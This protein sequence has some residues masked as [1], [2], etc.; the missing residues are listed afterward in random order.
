[1]RSVEN[2]T[3][4]CADISATRLDVQLYNEGA[5]AVVVRCD[6][7]YSLDANHMVPKRV[8]VPL[9]MEEEPRNWQNAEVGE[10]WETMR[11]YLLG[12]PH[13]SRS[14][15]FVSQDSAMAMKRAFMAMTESGMFGPIIKR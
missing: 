7:L 3:H 10:S 4:R 14:S 6:W 11:P 8:A 5:S 12:V 15:L 2:L 1:M 9:M 13:G